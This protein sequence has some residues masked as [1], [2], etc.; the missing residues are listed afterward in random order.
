MPKISEQTVGRTD[1]ALLWA[2]RI[3]GL[4]RVLGG[5]LFF[6]LLCHPGRAFSATLPATNS[7]ALAWDSSTSSA[8][9]GYR[10]YYGAA[11]GS[12]TSSVTVGNVTTGTV[13][14]LA[15]G[16][17]Y[18][19]TVVAR[20]VS[21]LESD[22]SNGISYAVPGALATVQIAVGS[23]RPV[24]LTLTG[25][26]GQIYVIEATQDFKT[27]TVIG[28]VTVGASGSVNLTDVN[29]ANFPKRFYRTRQ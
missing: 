12:Y 11:S 13:S 18:F 24:T 4:T 27:W 7:V 17:T 29:A 8:V 2:S 20:D 9:T 1:G 16:S 21:G 14:G 5:I 22:H 25:P 10:V 3:R 23:N 26:S 28:T 15:S 19:F 6:A